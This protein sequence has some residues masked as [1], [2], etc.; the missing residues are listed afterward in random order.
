MITMAEK[1][2]PSVTIAA[3]HRESSSTVVKFLSVLGADM[4]MGQLDVADYVLSDR[5]A[6][7]RKTAS[8]FLSSVKDQRIFEQLK[9]ISESYENPLLPM[10]GSPEQLFDGGL[11]DNSVRGALTSI[12]VDL[13]MPMIWTRNPKETAAQLYWIAYREQVKLER[14]IAIRPNKKV[15]HLSRMQEFLVAGLPNVNTVIGRRLLKEFRSPRAVF[16]AKEEKMMEVDGIG[17]E[18]AKK[19]ADLLDDEYEES[20]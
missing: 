4:K 12:A 9:R 8:D 1:A 16:A 3:D 11:H 18:K 15:T 17:R 20:E 6:V 19:I 5:V 7:E 13:G 2:T 14:S 10:E